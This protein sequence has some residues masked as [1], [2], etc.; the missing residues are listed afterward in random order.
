MTVPTAWMPAA[1]MQRIIVHWT[2]G[3]H[4]AS[5]LDRS[6]YHV[7]I[8]GNGTLV[9]G[10]PSIKLN[11][12]PAKAGYAAH[13]RNC[14]S[15]SIGV[16]MCC[17]AGAIERPFKAGS[18]PMTREQWDQMIL[19][20]ADLCKRYGI[21]VTPK[22]VL[23]HAEVQTN[24]GIAQRGKWDIARIAFLP[25]IVGAKACGDLMRR[26]VA[27][28]LD[29]IKPKPPPIPDEMKAERFR[30]AGVRPST[31]TFRDG[32]DG[33]AKGSLREG[34]IV[35]KLAAAG[36]WWQVRTPAGYIGWV[37]SSYLVPAL[38]DLPAVSQPPTPNPER[39]LPCAS[40]LPSRRRR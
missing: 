5:G 38:R 34:I 28:A 39:K 17:M 6:H 9:R 29:G 22:T 37:W 15:G 12:A 23:S 31:L 3:A 2:A 10:A 18:A 25:D 19:V 4:K 36:D 13:T 21:P 16:S 33:A 20:V 24:L 27:A 14:N 30:V 11:E 40:L 1:S 26:S 32:P 7:L 35:E 8:E